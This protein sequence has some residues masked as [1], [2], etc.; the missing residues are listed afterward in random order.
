[1]GFFYVAIHLTVQ[2]SVWCST[3]IKDTCLLDVTVVLMS[4]NKEMHCEQVLNDDKN[5]SK[6]IVEKSH[7]EQLIE[8]QCKNEELKGQLLKKKQHLEG[9]Q[10]EK[11]VV[12]KK[13]QE[14][15]ERTLQ[16]DILQQVK[17][18]DQEVKKTEK[19]WE[20]VDKKRAVVNGLEQEIAQLKE[21]REQKLKMV[22]KMSFYYNFLEKVI[23][24]TMFED[25]QGLINHLENLF[26]MREKLRETENIKL[27]EIAQKRNELLCL[28]DR[29]HVTMLQ[30]NFLQSQ[31]QME[32]E[33]YRSD[34]R[35]W[36]QKWEKIQETAAKK[37]L[38]LGQIKMA[39][40]N[41]YE[42][43]GGDLGEDSVDVNDTETQ[44]DRIASFI[45]DHDNIIKQFQFFQQKERE[46][47]KE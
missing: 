10:R 6:L 3:Q 7:T 44:L 38:M 19:Q 40:V 9:L 33:N 29:H 39:T 17:E 20:I 36:E 35:I 8:L 12:T 42:M 27:E 1:M 18:V 11:E 2:R 24:M 46:K 26:Y 45:Q 47:P 43:T 37:T 32:L 5:M 21:K 14:L 23:T 30:K 13:I 31:L 15:R 34:A 25:P 4:E 41:L 16:Y 28:E 22:E